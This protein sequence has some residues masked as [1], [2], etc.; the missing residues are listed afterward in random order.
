MGKRRAAWL[1]EGDD[2]RRAVPGLT[3]R[4]MSF[5][6]I[7]METVAYALDMRRTSLREMCSR[8]DATWMEWFRNSGLDRPDG[9]VG[10]FYRDHGRM[11]EDGEL[12]D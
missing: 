11:P 9:R 1:K 10:S 4:A 2:I 12:D 5:K 6:K 3:R 8:N 7:S